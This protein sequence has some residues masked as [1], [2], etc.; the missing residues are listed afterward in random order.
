MADIGFRR[1]H[2]IA[3]KLVLCSPP[4]SCCPSVEIHDDGAVLIGEDN[5]VAVLNF[6]QWNLL[7]ANIQDGTLWKV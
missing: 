6:F 7:I 5:R 1:P 3:Q 2:D 4:D